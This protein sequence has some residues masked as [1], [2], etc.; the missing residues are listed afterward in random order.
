M[1]DGKKRFAITS[2]P[3][4]KGSELT[5]TSRSSN[6]IFTSSRRPISSMVEIKNRI[7]NK[8]LLH[9]S[10]EFKAR[11]FSKSSQ[12]LSKTK[13]L[14]NMEKQENNFQQ[15]A[16]QNQV[17]TINLLKGNITNQSKLKSNYCKR[18]TLSNL[19]KYYEY[20]VKKV[21]EKPFTSSELKS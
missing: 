8:R 10:M 12:K 3:F 18:I 2:I 6:L 4:A 11:S 9:K 5:N 14:Q 19:E 13:E 20:C 21:Q 17:N 15:Y 16:S 7:C 1:K